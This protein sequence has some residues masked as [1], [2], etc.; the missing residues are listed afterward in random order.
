MALISSVNSY[1][2]SEGQKE[3]SK[4]FPLPQQ[5]RKY[6]HFPLSWDHQHG[7]GQLWDPSIPEGPW[8][9]SRDEIPSRLLC[10]ART[11]VCSS[12]QEHKNFIFLHSK[13]TELY[14]FCSTCPESFATSRELIDIRNICSVSIFCLFT[15]STASRTSSVWMRN[16]DSRRNSH[17]RSHVRRYTSPLIAIS[18]KLAEHNAVS[19]SCMETTERRRELPCA[20]TVWS[21]GNLNVEEGFAPPPIQL[22]YYSCEVIRYAQEER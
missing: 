4:Q 15:E 20:P 10:E 2:N 8:L 17:K 21:N 6:Q 7:I 9:P 3:N 5:V 13:Q 22:W 1:Q 19:F 12:L 16:T 14:Y 18:S 11:R